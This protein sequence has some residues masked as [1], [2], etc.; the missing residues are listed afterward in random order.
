MTVCSPH[1]RTSYL[2]EPEALLEQMPLVPHLRPGTFICLA[3]VMQNKSGPLYF[4]IRY[5]F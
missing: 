4:P 1:S 3:F 2:Q 5:R